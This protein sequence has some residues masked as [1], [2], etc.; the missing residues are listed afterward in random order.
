MSIERKKGIE[1]VLGKFPVFTDIS[2]IFDN[3]IISFLDDISKAI[4]SNKKFYKFPDLVQF[5]FWCRK[6][7]L[8]KIS[9]KYKSKNLMVGRGIVLHI[10]PSNVPLN[11]AYSFVFGML[12]G[13]TNLVR[14]PSRRFIQIDLLCKIIKDLCKKKKIFV[15][16][17]KNLFYKI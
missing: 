9:E 15:I 7:N 3:L 16:K 13:N 11:F 12:S 10:T 8:I 6:S 17:K 1:V 14:L 2:N 5:G 4:K